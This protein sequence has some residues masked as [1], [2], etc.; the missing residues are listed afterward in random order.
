MCQFNQRDLNEFYTSCRFSS[1]AKMLDAAVVNV[2]EHTHRTL[3][4]CL[5][6]SC[7]L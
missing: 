3:C 4:L 7:T 6:L 5:D 1:G 2:K